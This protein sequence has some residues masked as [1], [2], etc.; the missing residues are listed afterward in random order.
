VEG[1]KS[2]A[3]QLGCVETTD[4]IFSWIERK[5]PDVPDLV[6]DVDFRRQ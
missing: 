2:F 4:M 5:M 6:L 3:A 1:F